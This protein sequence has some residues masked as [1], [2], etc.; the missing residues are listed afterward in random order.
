MV[1]Q[2][3]GIIDGL[4]VE[5]IGRV[6]DWNTSG[7][8]ELAVKNGDGSGGVRFDSLILPVECLYSMWLGFV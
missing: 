2:L 6:M 8:V 1:F 5:F 7:L 4:P 3:L